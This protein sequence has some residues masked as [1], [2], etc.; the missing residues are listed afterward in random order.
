MVLIEAKKLDEQRRSMV[1]GTPSTTTK[2]TGA[3]GE[4]R[5]KWIEEYCWK[6]GCFRSQN[7]CND[8][9]DNLM[10]DFKKVREFERRRMSVK[11]NNS[12]GVGGDGSY[13]KMEKM[14]RKNH[15]LPSNLLPQIYEALAHVVEA[16]LGISVLPTHRKKERKRRR[17]SEEGSGLMEAIKG[18]EEREETRHKELYIMHQ[19]RYKI[20]ESKIE[21]ERQGFNGLVDAINNLSHSIL[22]FTSQRTP[23]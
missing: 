1:R 5:W 15:N 11:D 12:D 17:S 6:K 8:K 18:Y 16:K 22:A 19:K 9:W 2:P 7:Q 4:L 3:G 23:H 10:R 20:E 13:W 21:M 14:E